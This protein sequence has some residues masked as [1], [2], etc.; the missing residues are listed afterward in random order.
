MNQSKFSLADVLTVLAALAFGFVCF[1]G[2]N[3]YTLGNIQQSIILSLIIAVIL[4]GTAFGAKLF[5]RTSKNFKTGFVWEVILLVLFVGFAVFFA[6]APFPNYFVV[7]K[8]KTE[9]QDKLSASITQ[10]ENMFDKY[11]KYAENRENLYKNKLQSVVAA[12][13]INPRNYAAFGFDASGVVSDN[14]QIENKMFIVHADLFPTNYENIKQIASTWLAEAHSDVE[15]W[16]PIGIVDVVNDVE[17]NS[18]KWLN[19]LLQLSAIREQGEQADDFVYDL[20]F[21]DVKSSFSTLGKPTTT[22]I[23]LAVLADVLMLLSWFVAKRSTRFP[24][25][26]LLFAIGNAKDNEL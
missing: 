3:F 16:K 26:K 15:G 22:S 7:S 25:F 6:R 11:E 9:I 2:I 14:S 21:D 12:K 13:N 5:K 4:G 17:Q 23:C 20:S 19:N 1:L 18:E 8:H 24:G 10:A